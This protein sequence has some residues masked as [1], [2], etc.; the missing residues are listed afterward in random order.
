MWLRGRVKTG[1]V[2]STATDK[3]IEEFETNLH[4]QM[5]TIMH[6]ICYDFIK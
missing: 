6:L 4:V 2:L 5:P 3:A 1:L